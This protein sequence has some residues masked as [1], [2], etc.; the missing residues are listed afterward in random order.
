MK[1]CNVVGPC[2][3]SVMQTL[4]AETAPYAFMKD[5]SQMECTVDR[6]LCSNLNWEKGLDVENDAL[7]L[8]FKEMKN[9]YP[10][11]F[12]KFYHYMFLCEI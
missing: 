11:V 12:L 9:A 8:F 5:W 4:Q 2:M 10:H 7:F 1:E 6:W 3:V